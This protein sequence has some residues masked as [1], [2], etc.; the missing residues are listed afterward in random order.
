MKATLTLFAAT[1]ALGGL[2][3][4]PTMAAIPPLA[5]KQAGV[6]AI[7]GAAGNRTIL[8]ASDDDADGAES[9]DACH[10]SNDAAGDVVCGERED[11]EG[12]GAGAN[13]APAGTVAPPANGLFT[14]GAVPQVQ[15]K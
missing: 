10:R 9:D 1:A 3:T 15:V 2:F 14:K 12:G 8:L 7:A 4:L 5:A 6:T 11:D 13:A